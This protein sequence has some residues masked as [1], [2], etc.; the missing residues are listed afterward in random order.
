[1][2]ELRAYCLPWHASTSPAFNDIL[3]TPL[4]PFADIKPTP[5]PAPV[6]F[7]RP[8]IFCQMQPPPEIL[9]EPQ[10]R[11][12]WLPMWDDARH[13]APGWWST[14]PKKNFRVVAYAE[15]V[16]R[17]A[18]RAGLPTLRVRFHKDP[19]AAPAAR[20]DHRRVLFYWNR[21]GLAGPEFLERLCRET[22][23]N[24][25]I[26]RAAADPGST[27]GA[28]ELPTRFGA[29]DVTT[30]GG[31]GTK[32]DYEALLR[33]AN[34]FLAPRLYEGVG[35]TFLEAMSRGCAVLAHDS[36]TMNEYI[37]HRRNGWLFPSIRP[38][39]WRERLHA[40]AHRR[41]PRLVPPAGGATTLG[42]DQDWA[43]LRRTDWPALGRTARDDQAVGHRAWLARLPD[44]ARFILDW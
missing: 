33:E 30:L 20:W 34:L 18:A 27:Q 38:P 28:Y 9:A 6:D 3:V 37:V 11:I 36:P 21:T 8:L 41:W 26:F 13:F 32:E 24:R 31:F 16:R 39:L 42:L 12:V 7:N 1:M 43:T 44:F 17:E 22:C 23:A 2:P 14:L 15:P 19:A 35:L 5:W 10:A 25:L 4:R 40:G 29:T